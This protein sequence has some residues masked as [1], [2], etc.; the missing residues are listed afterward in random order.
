M[1]YKN[2]TADGSFLA[3]VKWAEINNAHY[4]TRVINGRIQIGMSP[5]HWR[6]A[7]YQGAA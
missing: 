2:V 1:R 5:Y 4:D 6:R 3:I 7:E